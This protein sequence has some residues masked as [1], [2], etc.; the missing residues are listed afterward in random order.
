MLLRRKM[1]S[2]HAGPARDGQLVDELVHDQ[3]VDRA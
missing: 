1:R 2:P 3:L